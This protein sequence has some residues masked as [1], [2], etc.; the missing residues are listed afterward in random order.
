MGMTKVLSIDLD[1]IM[2]P[3]I[4][5]YNSFYFDHNPSTRWRN[6]DELDKYKNLQ[7]PID[8]SS[9]MYCFN[10]FLKSLKH[11]DDISFGYEHD[12]ILY[13][14]SDCDNIELINIDHHDDVLSADFFNIYKNGFLD[15][16]YDEVVLSDR[17]HEGNWVSWLHKENK[18]D[19][20]V[21][22]RNENSANVS[23]NN[24]NYNLLKS[25]LDT[26][27]D[28]YKFIDYKFDKV[29][30][31]LSPQYVPREHW[32]YFSMFI[33]SYEEFCEKD[34]NIMSWANKKFEIEYRNKSVTNKVIKEIRVG[35]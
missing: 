15:K 4:E 6:L 33:S 28:N 8:Q 23:R 12:D 11:C 30:V 20:Y 18:L 24:F 25:Y 7:Y 22:I 26:T 10:V 27:R 34:A 17:V 31:C 5:T 3:V 19:S 32:H 1:Y 2:G 21:W 14:I 35:K 16:E 13:Q 9:L 29:F